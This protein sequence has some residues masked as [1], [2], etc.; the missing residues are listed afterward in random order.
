MITRRTFLTTMA[1]GSAAFLSLGGYAFGV[2]PHLRL[3]V[4]EYDLALPRWPRGAKPL[5]AALIADIH[6]VEPWMSVDRI[7]AIV[8][9]ANALN[10][11]IMLLLGDYVGTMLVRE[12]FVMPDE[13]SEPLADL[14]APLGVHAILGNHDWWWKGGPRPV[15]A[16]LERRGIRVLA[17]E[18]ERIDRDGHAFWLTGTDSM[19]AFGPRRPGADDLAGTLAR[20]TDDAPIIHLA[21]EPDLF[22]EVPERV[23]LTL[24]GHTHGGQVRMPALGPLFV[25][26]AYGDRFAYGHVEEASKH[27]IVSAGLGCSMLP[28]RF[29]SPPEIVF[30]RIRS[31]DTAPAALSPSS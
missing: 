25:P 1:T 4:T 7:A 31:A 17:N 21:H 19:V 6:A 24:S 9:T 29:L 23:A 30:L 16:A 14:K 22:V 8:A 12:R 27:L 15:R 26:S 13:W 3:L 2:E 18:A 10:P 20:V 5:T 28:V 11:D